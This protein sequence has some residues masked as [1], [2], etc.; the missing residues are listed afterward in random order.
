MFTTV[1]EL[2][3]AA[4][5][6][7]V[8]GS[9]FSYSG[10]TSAHISAAIAECEK[11]HHSL[12]SFAQPPTIVAG[13]LEFTWNL[14]GNASGKF[15]DNLTS[16]ISGMQSIH[17]GKHPANFYLIEND[18]ADGEGNPPDGL[19]RLHSICDLIKFLE[20]LSGQ[21]E[22]PV[23]LT[24]PLTLFVSLPAR[25]GLP[26][27]AAKLHTKI[28]AASIVGDPLKL[29]DLETVVNPSLSHTNHFYEK[30]ALFR[31]AV[32]HF[33]MEVQPAKYFSHLISKWPQ[34]VEKFRYDT[35]CYVGQYSFENFTS[36]LAEAQADFAGRLTKVMGDTA[37]KFLALPLPFVALVGISRSE[38]LGQSYLIFG[39]AAVL[40]LLYA[41]QVRNQ[42]L[43]IH[44]IDDSFKLVFDRLNL[45]PK[46][47]EATNG[48]SASLRRIKA[49]FNDQKRLL[50]RTLKVLLTIAWLPIAGGLV[51]LAY[52]YHPAFHEGTHRF[53]QEAHSFV[54]KIIG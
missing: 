37:T 50:R 25:D 33:L 43:E 7:Q 20:A 14:P 1:V 52:K 19:I 24:Q 6:P 41:A 39:G 12:G 54:E 22:G 9:T 46:D 27:Q 30:Q 40:A 15:Y 53:I 47:V 26:P 49:S 11:L 3:R 42:F 31:V 36:K 4:G 23:P 17:R 44:R 5:R 45:L 16:L 13:N 34:V 28:E 29:D 8:T 10:P 2:Y 35:E 51:M 21:I 48:A 38:E 18:Y 32:A